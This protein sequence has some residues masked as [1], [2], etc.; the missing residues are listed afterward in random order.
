[1]NTWIAIAAVLLMLQD[2]PRVETRDGRHVIT[3]AHDQASATRNI[4]IIG[5][6]LVY[7]NEMPWMLEQIARS[8]NA[9]PPLHVEFS[10]ASGLTLEQHWKM[11]K[12]L[13]RINDERWDF[14]VLQA[15]STEAV[16][17]PAAFEEY[18]K[19][20]DAA[21]RA[22]HAHTVI[23]ETWAVNDA[24]YPQ[25]AFNEEY[26]KVA[27][28]LGAT[29]APVGK[30]WSTLLAGGMQLFEDD[31]HPNVAGSYL[32]ACVL[33]AIA[34]GQSPSGAMH[35]FDVHFDIPEFYRRSLEHDSID[36]AKA[37]AIQA[38]AWRAVK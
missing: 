37:A 22:R 23:L 9:Q 36:A 21:I 35:T 4:L 11:G 18:A 29:L 8:K 19:R 33:Y 6:S 30:A 13:R 10:G 38:A 32:A 1:M 2:A 5:N 34:Y 26:E 16:R 17:T 25:H 27:Q 7:F 24:R 28:R 14:V 3:N 20:F 31:V 12:A 15:Q